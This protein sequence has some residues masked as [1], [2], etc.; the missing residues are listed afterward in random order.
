MG[1]SAPELTTEG[2]SVSAD[3]YTVG[4]TLAVLSFDFSGYTNQFKEVLPERA[5]VPLL[6]R[7]ES[8]D[9]FLRRATHHDPSARFDSAEEMAEQLLGVLREIV[10]VEDGVPHPA[11]SARFAA[12]PT[13]FGELVAHQGQLV[14]LT[15]S[16]EEAAAALPAPRT[17]LPAW[18]RG[19]AALAGGRFAAARAAF[20][21]VYSLLPGELPP[22]LALA[23]AAELDGDHE[24]AGR[25]YALVRAVDHG[26]FDAAFGLARTYL[27]VGEA[28]RAQ[29]LLREVA[30]DPPPEAP[31]EPRRRSRWRTFVS[32]LAAALLPVPPRRIP[33]EPAWQRIEARLHEVYDRLGP[34]VPAGKDPTP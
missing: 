22:K 8:Y 28:E 17:D 12:A 5:T 2:M 31:S 34:P 20:D 19:R 3:L 4:R 25:Y 24:A 18:T 14:P 32:G 10:A 33:P 23:A 16:P 26:R 30:G 1:Y 13:E 29:R 21:E 15:P 11:E 6:R 27:V 9:R 7:Y